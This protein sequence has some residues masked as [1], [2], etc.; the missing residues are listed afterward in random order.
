MG[1]KWILWKKHSRIVGCEMILAVKLSG[2]INS[3][4][5]VGVAVIV[6]PNKLV[7][8]GWRKSRW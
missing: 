4:A 8:R 3:I 1:S 5:A 6:L 7:R 2:Y